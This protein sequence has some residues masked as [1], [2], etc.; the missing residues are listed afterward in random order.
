MSVIMSVWVFALPSKVQTE[1]F[2]NTPAHAIK[3]ITMAV[4]QNCEVRVTIRGPEM[5]SSR[6]FFT[7][8]RSPST[9]EYPLYAEYFQH[10]G[11]G[12]ESG[13]F[14]VTALANESLETGMW[15]FVQI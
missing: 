1:S 4:V 9:Y 13:S 6:L 15:D 2:L 12:T 8:M 11:G 10:N 7:N 14:C 3:S 5:C